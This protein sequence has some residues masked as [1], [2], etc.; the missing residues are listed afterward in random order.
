[1]KNI[2]GFSLIEVMIVLVLLSLVLAAVVIVGNSLR[3]ASESFSQG[4]EMS[5][6][7]S[8]FTNQV[9]K[10]FE[11]VGF[12][13]K[14][15]FETSASGQVAPL[16]FS[17]D[18]YRVSVAND[19]ANISRQS[20]SGEADLFSVWGLVRGSS[21]ISFTPR[22]PKT[23]V[24]YRDSGNDSYFFYYADPQDWEI[25]AGRETILS[26]NDS[27]EQIAF[28][29]RVT[30]A[31]DSTENGCALSF[32]FLRGEERRFLIRREIGCK[33]Q[34]QPFVRLR[35]GGYVPDLSLRGSWFKRLDA[36]TESNL[37]P[38]LPVKNGKRS[39]VPVWIEDGGS[40]FTLLRSDLGIDPVTSTNAVEF[41][42]S[43]TEADITILP[44]LRGDLA[45]GDYCLLIDDGAQK[46]VLG[47]ITQISYGRQGVVAT[48][49]AAS[50]NFPAWNEFYSEDS[51]F[52]NHN[53][54]AGSR[55]IRLSEPVVYKFSANG[56][57]PEMLRREGSSPW[58]KVAFG[59]TESSL[60]HETSNGQNNFILNYSILPENAASVEARPV[61]LTFSPSALNAR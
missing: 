31:L 26:A 14:G 46:S 53:F 28:G 12:N 19:L 21:E 35:A 22:S 18:D 49:A 32:Y 16:F 27:T 11:T 33:Y 61:S 55:L 3:S 37:L 56:E 42:E 51:D 50:L 44:I 10:D 6:R 25:V 30:V 36:G 60:T 8:V 58:E 29:D 4:A 20:N 13:L 38:A 45:Q 23:T 1:M 57:T 5:D 47:K 34:Y 24:G 41:T 7:Q 2:R 48:F 43:S 52:I 39:A 54:P 9:K 40:T 59:V 15:S 17:S